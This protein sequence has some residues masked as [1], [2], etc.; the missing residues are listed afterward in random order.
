LHMHTNIE[1]TLVETSQIE[2][3]RVN[4]R[5]EL[6]RMATCLPHRMDADSGKLVNQH[7]NVQ[8]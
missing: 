8:Y 2:D 1:L 7:L 4:T 6:T 3:D 5:E